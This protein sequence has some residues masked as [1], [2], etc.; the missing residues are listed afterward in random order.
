MK[1]FEQSLLMEASL[2]VLSLKN[3]RWQNENCTLKAYWSWEREFFCNGELMLLHFIGVMHLFKMGKYEDLLYSF[4]ILQC[5]AF[6]KGVIHT[7]SLN[8]LMWFQFF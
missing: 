7:Y 2:S 4:F 1:L 3:I 8:N 5:L 6:L